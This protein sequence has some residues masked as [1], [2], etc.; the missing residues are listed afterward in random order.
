VPRNGTATVSIE[1]SPLP[2]D[3][4]R[5]PSLSGAPARRVVSV[6]WSATMNAE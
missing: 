3:A 4:Q 2:L 1:Y 6:T 5:T